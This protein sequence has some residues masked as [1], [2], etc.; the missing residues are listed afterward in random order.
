MIILFFKELC[1]KCSIKKALPHFSVPN[2]KT[3]LNF[4]HL[5][6]VFDHKFFYQRNFF[7]FKIRIKNN[8][9]LFRT[10]LEKMKV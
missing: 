1:I 4:F 7:R 3:H 9:L 2:F 6:I 5:R 10:Y 8:F